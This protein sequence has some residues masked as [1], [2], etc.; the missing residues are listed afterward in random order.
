LRIDERDPLIFLPEE[1]AADEADQNAE[2]R[3]PAKGAE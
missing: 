1:I 2:N 3:H